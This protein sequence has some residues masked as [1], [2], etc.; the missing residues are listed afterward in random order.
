MYGLIVKI[1]FLYPFILSKCLQLWNCSKH[2]FSELWLYEED[3][4]R[5]EKRLYALTPPCS[6]CLLIFQVLS[7]SLMVFL[8]RMSP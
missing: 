1:H 7:S 6:L 3:W 5:R 4:K 2:S 8:S